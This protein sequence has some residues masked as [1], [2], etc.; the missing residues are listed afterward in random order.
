GPWLP[1]AL[2]RPGHDRRSAADRGRSVGE[3]DRRRFVCR[4]AGRIAR[5]DGRRLPTLSTSFARVG[6]AFPSCEFVSWSALG[7]SELDVA[8]RHGPRRRAANERVAP[9]LPTPRLSPP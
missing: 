7:C 6:G 1:A 5:R 4:P 3:I 8:A 9:V 2:S